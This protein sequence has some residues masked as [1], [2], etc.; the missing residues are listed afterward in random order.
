[1]QTKGLVAPNP[2]RF[3]G[4]GMIVSGLLLTFP[5]LMWNQTLAYVAVLGTWLWLIGPIWL[6]HLS[7]EAPEK[8]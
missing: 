1:M 3:L 7:Q 2:V 6:I 8:D 5:L 4:L